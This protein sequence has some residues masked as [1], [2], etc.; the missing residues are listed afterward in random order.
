MGPLS[1]G[2]AVGDAARTS[3]Y[4][5]TVDQLEIQAEDFEIISKPAPAPN[6]TH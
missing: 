5:A 4:T 1:S 2:I 6:P 3:K